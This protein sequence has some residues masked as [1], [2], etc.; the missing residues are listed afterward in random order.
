MR[1]KHQAFESQNS[2]FYDYNGCGGLGA[3]GGVMVVNNNFLR[4]Q[5]SYNSIAFKVNESDTKL[6]PSII[7][8]KNKEQMI[9]MPSSGDIKVP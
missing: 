1:Q 8:V 4:E 3:G 9:N 6:K 2:S 7:I 5:S